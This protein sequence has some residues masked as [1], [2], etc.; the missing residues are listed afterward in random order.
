[1]LRYAEH[2]VSSSVGEK[3]FDRLWPG[4]FLDS[5]GGGAGRELYIQVFNKLINF[6]TTETTKEQMQWIVSWISYLN[7][8]MNIIAIS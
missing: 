1:M 2:N 4:F 7:L 8:A 6:T 5:E 3:F